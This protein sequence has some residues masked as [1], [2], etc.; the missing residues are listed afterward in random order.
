[1]SPLPPPIE[2]RV[3]WT[4]PSHWLSQ[5]LRKILERKKKVGASLCQLAAKVSI[6]INV[7]TY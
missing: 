7:Y 1:M 2:W 4:V 6:N 5:I 3:R